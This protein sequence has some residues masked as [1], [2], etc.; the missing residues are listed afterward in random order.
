[1]KN[2]GLNFL[3]II[4][5]IAL[6]IV[7]VFGGVY[8]GVSRL[9]SLVN[10]SSGSTEAVA[11]A[12]DQNSIDMNYTPA[13]S[14]DDADTEDGD[15]E[16]TSATDGTADNAI[17]GGSGSIGFSDAVEEKLSEMTTEE[18]VAQLFVVTPDELMGMHQVTQAGSSTEEALAE[19]PVGGLL[20]TSLNLQGPDQVSQMISNTQEYSQEAVGL[21]VFTMIEEAG[22]E[23]HSPLAGVDAGDM[24]ASPAELGESASTED[25][26]T[27]AENRAAYA[28]A[29]GINTILG[30]VADTAADPA[31][32]GVTADEETTADWN[33]MTYG[34]DTLDVADCVESDVQG[35]QTA[36][37]MAVMRAFP[38]MYEAADDYSAYQV[39]IDTD[40]DCIQV[41][42][43]ADEDLTG[44]TEL[45]CC[46]SSDA[47]DYL[48]DTM[49]FDG[50][51]MSVDLA[52][53]SITGQYD[54]ADAAVMAVQAGIDL[55]Y[56]S[57]GFTDAYQAVLDAVN[58]GSIRDAVLTNAVGRILS[59]KMD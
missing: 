17:S 19:Y 18:K 57:D 21:D 43:I 47:V 15:N 3:I 37:A 13:G 58:D 10:G 41:S 40:V 25:I 51:L 16:D 59:Q 35:T 8:G 50:I 38:G 27:A 29:C 44:D 48:R 1:M 42:A 36:G 33:E 54:T 7:V 14:S 49:G 34:S 11:D 9:K 52:D 24:E 31:G 4:E 30:P 55:I 28:L 45:P 23:N 6:V 2:R 53:E 20:Y 26:S 39:G 5:V 56:V 46:L 12:E 22:G 32:E